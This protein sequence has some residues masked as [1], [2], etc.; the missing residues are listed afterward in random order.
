VSA[1]F[2]PDG[3]LTSPLLDAKVSIP[4]SRLTTVPR[5]ELW[6]AIR[7][8]RQARLVSVT[9]S[10]GYGKTT[11]LAEGARS[12][13][14]PVAWV[15]L[16]A[17]DDDP[18]TLL[19]AIATSFARI[20]PAQAEL[21]SEMSRQTIS[22][23]GRAAP[24]LAQAFRTT[25]HPFV[26]MLDDVHEIRS[27]ISADV[28]DLLITHLPP[29]S[30][31]ITASRHEPPF[32]PSR[33]AR[34]ETLEV[35][36][37]DLA[38]TAAQAAALFA[39]AGITLTEGDIE[40]VVARTEG[41]PAGLRLAAMIARQQS[42]AGELSPSITGRD[43]I[44]ADYLRRESLA[45]LPEYVRDFV[46]RSAVLDDMCAPLCNAVLGT[47]NAHE[48]L[49]QLE[50]SNQFLVPLDR[51]RQWYR[52][53]AL[54]RDVLRQELEQYDPQLVTALHQ[55]AARWFEEHGLPERAV[56]H[57]LAAG[58]TDH[59]M[60]LLCVLL[61]PAYNQGRAS[62]V[63]RWMEACGP[64][65]ISSYPPLA[66]M[67]GWAAT[68]AGDPHRG[69]DWAEVIDQATFEGAPPDGSA[70]FTSARAMLRGLRCADG[71]KTMAVD[72]ERALAEE[73]V[74]SPWRDMALFITAE[75]RLLAG[76]DDD[77]RRLLDECVP[78]AARLGHSDAE[79]FARSQR[80]VL[81][82][83]DGR[84]GDAGAD[85]EAALDTVVV[86]GIHDHV[87]AVLAYAVA[88]RAAVARGDRA[89]ALVHAAAAMAVRAVCTWAVP[90]LATRARLELVGVFVA[91]ED[92][93]PAR[94]LLAEIDAI[95]RRR[96]DL[97]VLGAEIE[98]ARQ[99]MA[100]LPAGGAGS[101]ALTPAESRVL[102]YLQTHLTLTEI[103]ERLYV[104]RNTVS[105]HVGS[106]YRKLA[107]SSRGDA[108]DRAR[109]VGLL[110]GAELSPLPPE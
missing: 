30:Q 106:I 32:L 75:A 19:T 51:E 45:A 91:L 38:F 25:D 64:E 10:A 17:F 6:A 46:I 96:P 39:H 44:I 31:V 5:P 99:L 66:V 33:R 107:V 28:I 102:D 98:R 36:L 43:R 67:A 18:V 54:Y 79:V 89:G 85:C 22:V 47:G 77:A 12:D 61:R 80:A 37:E 110:G 59:L 57:L 93:P 92:R 49:R 29:G 87:S 34:G 8:G 83:A 88:A 94:E 53:H 11:L 63:V 1:V 55:R 24:R 101:P 40:T 42:G 27:T 95:Q 21:P 50:R 58:D 82:L 4:E 97:G 23:L 103:G 100:A 9:A 109:Q 2:S 7:S 78:L 108:V 105:T 90:S 41:W 3:F 76:D 69:D 52:Y 70:S 14:R 72:A 56:D 73:P 65:V 62:T 81:A 60:E 48:V 20:E 86:A 84:V 35:G 104:S 74:W 26:L 71:I 16:D 68:L 13:D 15:T